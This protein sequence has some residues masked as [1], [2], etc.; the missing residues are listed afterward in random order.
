MVSPVGKGAD[1]RTDALPTVEAHCRAIPTIGGVAGAVDA[2]DG[3][4][5]A[6]EDGEVVPADEPVFDPGASLP[7]AVDWAAGAEILTEGAE[8]VDATGDDVDGA[9]EAATLAD[10]A[11]L[12]VPA[13]GTEVGTVCTGLWAGAAELEA[14]AVPPSLTEPPFW[15][16]TDAAG[17]VVGASPRR[18]VATAGEGAFTSGSSRAVNAEA[19]DGGAPP[20]RAT[21]AARAPAATVTAAARARRR[22]ERWVIWAPL[23]WRRNRRND[24]IALVLRHGSLGV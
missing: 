22:G 18:G 24:Q 9:L 7:A 10:G 14:D 6:A 20:A 21:A 8:V 1:R 15:M 17:T 2:G 12:G 19:L 23:G 5:L 3:A 16:T 11:A 4:L 13:G